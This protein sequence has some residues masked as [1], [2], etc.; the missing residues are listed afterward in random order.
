[1]PT[2]RELGVKDRISARCFLAFSI[3]FGMAGALQAQ[4]PAFLQGSAGVRYEEAP[5]VFHYV[6]SCSLPS[7]G[8]AGAGSGPQAATGPPA[9]CW[10]IL[11]THL[12]MVDGKAK[13]DAPVAGALMVSAELAHFLPNDPKA[14]TT[15]PDFVPS[16]ALLQYDAKHSVLG[17]QTK[18]GMFFLSLRPICSGCTPGGPALDP[19]KAAQLEAEYMEIQSSLKNFD[20]VSKRI[21]D[22]ADHMRFGVTP[23]D[24][25]TTTDLP[26]AM[27]LYS[28]L[29]HRLAPLCPEAARACVQSY[30]KYQGCKSG[31]PQA[32]CG[33]PPSCSAFCPLLADTWRSLKATFCRSP[34]LDYAALVPDWTPVALKMDAARAA[35]GPI[36]PMK[37]H[38][39]PAPAGA[40]L[41][42]M[43]KPVDPDNPCSVEGSYAMAMMSHMTAAIGMRAPPLPG[44]AG[45]VDVGAVDGQHVKKIKVDGR[46]I[47]GNILVKTRPEYPAV[48][49][50]ARIQGTVVLQAVISKDGTVES[51]QVL[52]GPPLLQQ[53]ALDAVK[54]WK[55]RPYLLNGEPVAVGTTINVVFALGTLPPAAPPA[56]EARPPQ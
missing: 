34:K 10:L 36:D 50:A 55:Y 3:A 41:D 40:Q 20:V 45:G 12:E 37:I 21:R 31:N 26:E 8:G 7:A 23:N 16:Q 4:E 38:V 52:E 28:D 39:V 54:T 30:E 49:K 27:A 2:E 14:T 51:L 15:L 11:L 22:L 19:N 17:L 5:G 42:F 43:G 1:M 29:N 18:A 33:T 25:P 48:A 56:Q 13:F 35:R 32:D 6:F 24:Q 9:L 47:A 46:V 53:A 44:D